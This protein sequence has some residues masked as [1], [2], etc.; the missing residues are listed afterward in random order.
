MTFHATPLEGLFTVE[1][2]VFQDERGWFGRT[3]C[4]EEFAAIGHS[5]EWT[6]LN[7]SFT[8]DKAAIRGLHYQRPPF[9][10]IKMVRCISGEVFDVAVDLR[11]ASP[12]FLHWF[13]TILSAENK[14]MLYI[15]VGFAHGFQTLTEDCEL[16]Y[17]HSSFYT[18]GYERGIRFDDP[19]LGIKWPLE[20]SVISQRD[21]GLPYLAPSFKGI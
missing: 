15:P 11:A 4:K 12:T 9:S 14:R 8:K 1:L 17:H 10:E 7:H 13:G 16:L 5:A 21:S 19:T 18:P 20:L 3:Y 6:Q 2:S